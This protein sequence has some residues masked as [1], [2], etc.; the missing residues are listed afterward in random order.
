[1]QCEPKIATLL[2]AYNGAAFIDEQIQTILN[3]DNVDI[4]L[5]IS[6]DFSE[7][8][9]LKRCLQ[10][11]DN[12]SRVVVLPYGEVYGGAAANFFRL[13]VDADI[14]DSEYVALADQDDI[15]LPRKLIRAIDVIT[16]SEAD[17]YS[18]NVM[19]F[20]PDGNCRLIKKDFKLKRYDH[21]FEAA[22]PGCTY[23]LTKE[24]Y[25]DLR[26]TIQLK[27]H[28]LSRVTLH[29]WFIYAFCRESK[30]SWVIDSEPH[31]L[32]RQHDK[33]QVGSNFGFDAFLKRLKMIGSG[34]YGTQV[35]LIAKILE[36][37]L[38]GRMWRISSFLQLRR[39]PRDAFLLL[40]LHL[41]FY[42]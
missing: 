24:I 36:V 18:A 2:A 9:T 32:Y 10:Y 17:G 31:M 40:V 7:D 28:D 23:V 34:W 33:N 29:D 27:R 19:A 5:H 13:I 30:R 42:L 3:Q 21:F 37:Q 39:R 22:G 20:W 4:R 15:W 12:D 38:K 8:D 35:E 41:L 6:V 16:N 14:G 11:Q 1:M 25:F 26:K